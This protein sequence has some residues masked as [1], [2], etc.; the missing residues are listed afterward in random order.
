MKLLHSHITQKI[1]RAYFNVYN[2]LGYG[3]L[4]KVYEN[5]MM[6]ELENKCL[7]ATNQQ[8]IKVTYQD[9]IIGEYKTDIIVE[10]KVIVELK[11]VT[12]L[13]EIHEVQLLNYLKA[14]N[15]EVGLLLNFGHKPEYARKVFSKKYKN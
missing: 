4:E 9:K 10:D 3:F 2:N 11:A 12:G 13:S 7:K 5:A 1:L 8:P 14:T 6:I 15:I